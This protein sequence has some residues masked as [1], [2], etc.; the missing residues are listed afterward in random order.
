[1]S[2]TPPVRYPH[3][4]LLARLALTAALLVAPALARAQSGDGPLNRAD[5]R[6]DA[7]VTAP[8]TIEA[9]AIVRWTHRS[10]TPAATAEWH[11]YANAFARGSLF[12]RTLSGGAHRGNAPGAGGS[13]ELHSLALASGE[14][15]LPSATAD[16]GDADRTRLRVTLPRPVPRDVET[17]FSLRFTVR[18]PDAFSRS[19]CGDRFCFAGQWFPKLAVYE[20]DG[21][22]STFALHAQSEFYAD[23]GRYELTVDAPATATVFAT[24]RRI[25]AP[26]FNAP[27]RARHAFALARAHDC[28]FGWSERGLVRDAVIS[29]RNERDGDDP[30][31]P[32][33]VLVRAVYTAPDAVGAERAIALAQRALPALERRY[34]PYPYDALTIVVAPR[35]AAGIGGMEYPGLVTVE[36]NPFAPSF[37]RA[38]EYVT[39]HELAH[40]WFYGVIATNEHSEPA[41]DE[42][43]CE[44]ATGLVFD[45]LYGEPS[46]A[47]AF[48]LGVS[49]WA[50]QGAFSNLERDTGPIL[51]NATLFA[52]FDSYANVVYRRTSALFDSV[53]R[54]H[55]AALDRALARYAR[56]QRFRHPTGRDL[57]RALRAEP[58]LARTVDA[59]IEPA[60]TT[61]SSLGDR[62]PSAQRFIE[63]NRGSGSLLP[64]SSRLSTVFAVLLRWIGP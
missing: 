34:G 40:Q 27:G 59:V 57:L 47:R 39:A 7:R 5:Y 15:L 37:V 60:F 4:D 43:L 18:L 49:F 46:L 50:M 30:D 21:R 17:V 24:G 32:R 29:S 45:E 41:L 61:R 13:I 25:R 16:F 55:P 20:R 42:G 31:A 28:A 12:L 38:V 44:F 48:G 51:R 14:E 9:T 19:G 62:V 54:E 8:R 52:D 23:F 26:E 1:M 64:L 33:P 53:R 63:H 2:Q 22:W 56:E 11:L 6:L 10:D 35:D 58:E 36:S 3:R